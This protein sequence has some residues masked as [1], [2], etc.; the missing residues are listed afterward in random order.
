MEMKVLY[1]LIVEEL[2]P[3]VPIVTSQ[4]LLLQSS[5]SNVILDFLS[6]KSVESLVLIHKGDVVQV[7][8]QLKLC[9]CYTNRGPWL[10]VYVSIIDITFVGVP[11]FGH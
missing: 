1:M 2:S 11:S 8:L 5:L 9:M 6:S 10:K 4:C 3:Y 7:S